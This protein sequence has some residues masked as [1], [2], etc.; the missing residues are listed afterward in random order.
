MC[1]KLIQEGYIQYRY[2]V[3][4]VRILATSDFGKIGHEQRTC[5]ARGK[6]LPTPFSLS[7]DVIGGYTIIIYTH[8]S[9]DSIK[10]S[11][12]HLIEV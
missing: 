9:G 12:A 11:H 1:S 4:T 3:Y 2:T 7:C 10:M 8:H 6:Y 5:A